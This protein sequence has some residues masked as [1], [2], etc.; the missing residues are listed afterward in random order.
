MALTP[1]L[2]E[3]GREV[4]EYIEREFEDPSTT[5]SV[6]IPSHPFLHAVTERLAQIVLFSSIFPN[7]DRVATHD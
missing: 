5:D 2:N 1:L 6:R 7:F 4:A 3:V